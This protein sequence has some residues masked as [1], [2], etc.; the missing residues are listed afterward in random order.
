[1]KI[2]HWDEMFHPT[3]GYQ[4]NLLAK[5]QAYEGHDVTI[6]TSANIKEHPTFSNFGNE[7]DI[8]LEDAIYSK[9]HGVKIIRLPNYGTVSGRVIY[10][11]GYL[12]KIINENP[13]I[14]MCHTNDT[15]SGMYITMRHKKLE[16]PIV[17]DNHMLEMASRNPL[18]KFF[19]FFF[20]KLITPIII[21]NNFIVIRTQNDNYVNKKLG[22]PK[23]LTP[24]IS[25]GTDTRLFKPSVENNLDFRKKHDIGLDDF[26]VIYAGKLTKEKGTMLLANAMEKKINDKRVVFVIIGNSLSGYAEEVVNIMEESENR[27]LFFGTQRYEDLAEFYQSA[28]LAIFPKQCSLSFYDVQACGIPVILENNTVNKERLAHKNGFLFQ[29]NNSDDLRK[30]IVDTVKL[31]SSEYEEMSNNSQEFIKSNYD[32]EIITGHYSNVLVEEYE[33]FHK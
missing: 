8:D 12:K 24:F 19:R 10:K 21:K 29:S 31:T 7:I 28:N 23:S 3:F 18:S 2:V 32:Y 15:L 16:M 5:F 11:K 33:L 17:F 27:T 13:D 22:I 26:I 1:M 9:K 30:K 4:I 20:R 25:F 14:L 6:I